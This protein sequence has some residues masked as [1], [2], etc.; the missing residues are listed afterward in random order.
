MADEP[1]DGPD[2][3]IACSMSGTLNSVVHRTK[4]ETVVKHLLRALPASIADSCRVQM[5]SRVGKY[6]MKR[7]RVR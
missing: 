3:A 2:D 4:C 5:R 1:C 6:H 7:C